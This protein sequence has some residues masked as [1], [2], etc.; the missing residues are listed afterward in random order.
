MNLDKISCGSGDEVKPI[1]AS[2]PNM[3]WTL[4]YVLLVSTFQPWCEMPCFDF[5]KCSV[6]NKFV[7]ELCSKSEVSNA[8]CQLWSNEKDISTER[9]Q[10]AE[11]LKRQATRMRNRS[12]KFTLNNV[13]W[14]FWW[15]IMDG[16][17]GICTQVVT[18]LNWRNLWCR[19]LGLLIFKMCN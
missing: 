8:I 11:S 7:H 12:E 15:H 13:K 2:L 3:K 14:S 9:S 16:I 18:G 10:A 6:C 5:M 19:I 17:I 1:F 4:Y